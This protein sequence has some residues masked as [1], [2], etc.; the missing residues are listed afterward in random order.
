MILTGGLRKFALTAHVVVS[1]GWI[2]AVA[3]FLALAIAGV[4]SPDAELV[5]GVYRAMQLTTWLVIVPLAFASLATGIVSSLGTGWG[6]FRYYWVVLKLGITALATFVLMMH[7]RPIDL[8]AVTA[9]S[10]PRM[11]AGLRDQ[12]WMMMTASAGAVV[13]LIVATV[14]SVYKP[15]GLTGYGKR[16][17]APFTAPRFARTP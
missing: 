7:T 12:E 2:G 14:L 10:T 9:A 13:A 16:R 8:L 1:V 6:L 17:A 4:A 15:Q 11:L 3:C 5:R